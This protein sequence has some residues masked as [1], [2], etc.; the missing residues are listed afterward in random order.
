M[1]VPVNSRG[2]LPSKAAV[3]LKRQ[4]WDWKITVTRTSLDRFAYQ[5]VFPYLSLYIVALGATATELGFVNGLGMM[6]AGIISP[7]TGWFIDRSG[8]KKIYLLGIGFLA[9]SYLTYA[10][11]QSWLTTV[12]AMV[13]YWLGFSV[14]IHSCATICGNCLANEDRATGMT[15][16]ETVAAGLLGMAGPMLGAWL[17]TIFGGV[18]ASGIRPLFFFSSI[19]TVITFTII[20]TRLSNKKGR[21]AGGTQSNIFRDLHQVLKEGQ[22]LNRWLIISAIN[23]LPLAMVFPF[24]QVFAHEIKGADPFILGAMVTGSALT[25]I[26]FAIPLGR[27]ADRVGRKKILY[28]TM[29]LFWGSNLM[30][31]WATKPAFL[32]IAGIL[33]GFFYIGAPIAAAMERELVPPEQMGRWLGIVRFSRMLLN[34]I[35]AVISGIIWDRIGPQY[36]FWAF[37]ALDLILRAPLLISMPET[38]RLRVGNQFPES[39]KGLKTT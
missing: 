6:A 15:I 10:I 5:I 26:I 14:S 25:S 36:V 12:L 29:P 8:P 20:L 22:H 3:F 35:V 30:L 4:Q 31:V 28:L 37:I 16:C 39:A 1:G 11:A 18:N 27:L 38:L 13:T 9:I 34:A 2:L 17:V 32:L 7:L 21:I 23:S 24:S 33:Q 19:I